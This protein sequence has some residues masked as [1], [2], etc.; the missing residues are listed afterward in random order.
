MSDVSQGQGWWLASDG[1][2]YAPELAPNATESV[3][4]E[5]ATDTKSMLR[6]MT[7]PDSVKKGVHAALGALETSGLAK[8]DRSSGEIKVKKLGLAKAAFRPG[9]T[10]RKAINGAT[11]DLVRND[12]PP[13]T[14][15]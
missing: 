7:Q 3:P 11:A 5:R 12:K 10:L 1:K 6:R 4:Q 14:E 9:K 8:V 15:S 13:E 2:W